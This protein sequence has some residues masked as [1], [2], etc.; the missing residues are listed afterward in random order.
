MTFYGAKRSNILNKMLNTGNIFSNVNDKKI[1]IIKPWIK[2]GKTQS[3]KKKEK[4][5]LDM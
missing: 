5:D 2:M 4:S 1:L 3:T